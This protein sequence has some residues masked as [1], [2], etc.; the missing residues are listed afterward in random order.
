[1]FV[2]DLLET[3]NQ[4]K[5]VAMEKGHPVPPRGAIGA[6]EPMMHFDL[7]HDPL[8]DVI[9]AD[10]GLTDLNK[11][12]DICFAA[13]PN[14]GGGSLG[15]KRVKQVSPRQ[16]RGKVIRPM[17]AMLE[18]T[19]GVLSDN[20]KT[21]EV[22]STIF[23]RSPAGRWVGLSHGLV[24]QYHEQYDEQI[25]VM[26]GMALLKEVQWRVS[27]LREGDT[28]GIEVPT[29][30]LGIS[31]L[32]ATRDLPEG[33]QRRAALQHWVEEHW[34]EIRIDPDVETKVRT[35][36]RGSKQFTWNGLLCEVKPALMDEQIAELA[37][38]ERGYDRL[39][40]WDRRIEKETI[41]PHRPWWRRA[42]MRLRGK[43]A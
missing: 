32:F 3:V 17:P 28:I 15:F 39:M 22:R 23:G 42:M 38:E 25:G 35:H 11:P 34:R 8:R 29:D 18:E 2:V 33:R 12:L 27:F 40:G 14:H 37:K 36:L 20:Q 6:L 5:W 24:A 26:C 10:T 19:L 43:K 7:T 9:P 16:V 4:G 30:P 1:M 41:T 21:W 31:A 13:P